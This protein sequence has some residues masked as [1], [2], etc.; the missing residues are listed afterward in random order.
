[1]DKTIVE[2]PERFVNEE[3]NE[4]FNGQRL[5]WPNGLTDAPHPTG[6]LTRRIDIVRLHVEGEFLL[7]LEVEV[8]HGVG[9]R[10]GVGAKVGH[11]AEHCTTEGA[12][13]LLQTKKTDTNKSHNK[14][15]GREVTMNEGGASG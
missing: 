5:E 4:S 7:G 2:K 15:Y 10:I 13:D 3:T 12:V 9:E 6:H 8:N 14:H 1:M 11:K